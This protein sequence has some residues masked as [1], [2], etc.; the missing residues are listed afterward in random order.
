MSNF[1]SSYI[2]MK[3]KG[4]FVGLRPGCTL[5]YSVKCTFINKPDPA[6]A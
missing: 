1:Y 2:N 3:I 4:L 6:F 5:F